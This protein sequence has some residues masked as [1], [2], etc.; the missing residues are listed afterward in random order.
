MDR[1]PTEALILT[2][3]IVL[4]QGLG[5]LLESLTGITQVTALKEIPGS[6]AWIETHMPAIVLLDYRLTGVQTKSVL[7]SV[8]ELSPNTR[9][10][11]LVDDV[12]E[13]NW[14]P[15]YAD[16]VLIRGIPPQAVA[17]LLANLLSSK[18]EDHEHID[19]IA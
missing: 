8:Q 16:A 5:A 4:Q 13:V 19:P 1:Q 11:L 7:A 18:G 10:V 12:Q 15:S 3:S 6:F 9:R 2:R 14:V 17:T